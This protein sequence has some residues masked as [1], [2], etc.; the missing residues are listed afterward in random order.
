M[1][2]TEKT[3]TANLDI[4][5]YLEGKEEGGNGIYAY[6]TVSPQEL[7][8]FLEKSQQYGFRPGD[9]GTIVLSGYGQPTDDDKDALEDELGLVH[10]VL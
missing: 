10:G 2:L 1:Q 7:P 9:Y 8:E 4:L 6:V 3:I 5:F